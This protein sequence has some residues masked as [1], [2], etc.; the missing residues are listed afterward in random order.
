MILI[1]FEYASYFFLFIKD[2]FYFKSLCKLLSQT[3]D[4]IA[5]AINAQKCK[6]VAKALLR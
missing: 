5:M 4:R 6:V 3:E 2:L 1:L